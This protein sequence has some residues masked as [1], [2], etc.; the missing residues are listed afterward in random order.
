[1]VG[2][3][4]RLHLHR[5]ADDRSVWWHAAGHAGQDDLPAMQMGRQPDLRT[6]QRQ[7]AAQPRAEGHPVRPRQAPVQLRGRCVLREQAPLVRKILP[8]SGAAAHPDFSSVQ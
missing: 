4:H 6:A 8:V 7:R 1:M 2:R 5:H 3:V